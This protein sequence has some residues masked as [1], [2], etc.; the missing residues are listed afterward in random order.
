MVAGS[1]SGVEVFPVSKIRSSA[2]TLSSRGVLVVGLSAW[3][4]MYP[5]TGGAQS[6]AGGLDPSLGSGGKVVTDL[7][8]FDS[9]YALTVQNDGKI[10]A[11]GTAGLEFGLARHNADGN[12][13][14]EFG[15]G[16]R[17]TTDF[18]DSGQFEQANAVGLQRDGKIVAAGYA[19]SAGTGFD[20]ALARYNSD[21]GLD[22]DFGN[23]GKVTTDFRGFNSAEAIYALAIQGDDKIIAAG[24]TSSP[25]FRL[26][27]VF[28]VARYNEDGSLDQTFGTGGKVATTFFEITDWNEGARAVALQPDGRIVAAGSAKTDFAVA[29]FNTDG[30]LD[31][32]FGDGGKVTTDFDGLDQALATLVNAERGTTVRIRVNVNRSGGFG[33]NVSVSPPDGSAIKVKFKPSGPISSSEATLSFKAKI[34]GGAPTGSHQLTFTARDE[35][36]RTRSATLTMRIQ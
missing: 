23:R 13:D 10:I 28:G 14:L 34:K 9:A 18:F 33:G 20:F 26:N 1:I 5:L 21:G 29:R 32:T 6:G 22:K 8:G 19:A 24:S 17:L 27:Q 3:F 2:K 12:L 7:G 30:S 11:A 36:G 16:G 35:M 25:T 15:D 4:A 31:T